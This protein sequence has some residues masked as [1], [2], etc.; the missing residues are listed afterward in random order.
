MQ[1]VWGVEGVSIKNT[2]PKQISMRAHEL[3][4][5][6]SQGFFRLEIHAVVIQAPISPRNQGKIISHE[7]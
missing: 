6:G 2:Q 1:S 3:L 4:L 7:S 5:N